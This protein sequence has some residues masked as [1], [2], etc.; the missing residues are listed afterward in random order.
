MA[1]RTASH[2]GMRPK[3]VSPFRAMSRRMRSRTSRAES[4]SSIAGMPPSITQRGSR[5]RSGLVAVS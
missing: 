5:F 1:T 4:R 2:D 3:L